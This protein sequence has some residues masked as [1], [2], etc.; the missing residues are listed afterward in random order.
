MK[1]FLMEG[2]F[3]NNMMQ[4]DIGGDLLRSITSPKN[5]VLKLV[6]V[7]IYENINGPPYFNSWIFVWVLF[8]L[9]VTP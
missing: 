9:V 6:G 8:L 7:K 2:V 1:L 3:G 5:I 4:A